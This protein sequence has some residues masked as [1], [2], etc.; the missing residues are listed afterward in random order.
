MSGVTGN[1]Y[2]F[3]YIDCRGQEEL[4][5]CI[6]L[7]YCKKN[8]RIEITYLIVKTVSLSSTASRFRRHQCR[9]IGQFLDYFLI[10]YY[11]QLL[12]IIKLMNFKL[13][14]RKFLTNLTGS[15]PVLY[16]DM[17]ELVE[18]P[19]S[20]SFFSLFSCSVRVLDDWMIDSGERGFKWNRFCARCNLITFGTP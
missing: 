2:C 7:S 13:I 4:P 12:N 3:I 19:N 9:K 14:S 1:I 16:S 17:F 18:A 11:Y 20:F 6:E 5:Y 10:L 15:S 8:Y